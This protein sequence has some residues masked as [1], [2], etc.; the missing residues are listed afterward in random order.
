MK[1]M[2]A[3]W[4]LMQMVETLYDLGSLGECHISIIFHGEEK[5]QKGT[6]KGY[7]GS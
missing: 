5:E 6:G 2:I 4:V 3:I 1:F 7:P